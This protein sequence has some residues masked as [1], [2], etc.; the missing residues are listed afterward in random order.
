MIPVHPRGPLLFAYPI[1]AKREEDT[2]EHANMRGKKSVNPG[3]K[4]WDL[5]PAAFPDITS[6]SGP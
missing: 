6:I 2:A 4:S 5:R 3:F 1:P